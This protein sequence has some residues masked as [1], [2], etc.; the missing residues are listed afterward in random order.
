M[1]QR[2]SDAA[3]Q[4]RHCS[5]TLCTAA[6][7]A[8]F[9]SRASSCEQDRTWVTEQKRAEIAHGKLLAT[10]AHRFFVGRRFCLR[11]GAPVLQR[12]QELVTEGEQRDPCLL[13]ARVKAAPPR[14][15]L[16][17]A[18]ERQP[19]ASGSPYNTAHHEIMRT[20]VP[21]NTSPFVYEPT[22]GFDA[23][24]TV[25]ALFDALDAAERGEVEERGAAVE[26]WRAQLKE[27]KRD[28]AVA[29]RAKRLRQRLNGLDQWMRVSNDDRSSTPLSTRMPWNS[30]REMCD[31]LP[32][33]HDAFADSPLQ[34]LSSFGAK[35]VITSVWRAIRPLPAEARLEVSP[36]FAGALVSYSPVALRQL[37]PSPTWL[38]ARLHLLAAQRMPD[39]M[40]ELEL[41]ALAV[42]RYAPTNSGAVA[43]GHAGRPVRLDVLLSY[44]VP[45]AGRWSYSRQA[46]IKRLYEASGAAPTQWDLAEYVPISPRGG[47][48]CTMKLTLR[49]S[50]GALYD[51]AP[52]LRELREGVAAAELDDLDAACAQL[53][54]TVRRFQD[55]F[56]AGGGTRAGLW[57]AALDSVGE[58]L[59]VFSQGRQSLWLDLRTEVAEAQERLGAALGALWRH[60]G[61]RLARGASGGATQLL[62][63]DAVGL[64]GFLAGARWRA[65]LTPA[66][67][68][69]LPLSPF[70]HRAPF[71]HS[72]APGCVRGWPANPRRHKHVAHPRG[73]LEDSNR[74][75]LVGI[76]VMRHYVLFERSPVFGAVLS[77]APAAHSAAPA[78]RARPE[79]DAQME[80]LADGDESAASTDASHS[81][82]E[83]D[84]D[85][86]P[87]ALGV[88]PL[89]PLDE[90]EAMLSS[91]D[92]D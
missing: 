54:A 51:L 85:A 72:Q 47:R 31:A 64:T 89:A 20:R 75:A 35:N 1:T 79:A 67:V 18:I 13:A 26:S 82:S 39:T 56:A 5:L 80:E 14:L 55:A 17:Y 48:T 11:E 71:V 29:N 38:G 74:G 8:P 22:A 49:T 30:V 70:V 65:G 90:S 19:T 15:Q 25:A 16:V 52:A 91:D 46:G 32:G 12:F 9:D 88:A 50:L 61:R 43:A 68:A 4:R 37:D 59:P 69:C 81:S 36:D 10:R 28:K 42:G 76:L 66:D 92:G 21:E 45:P 44:D 33:L 63:Y 60:V 73:D 77:S 34:D 27:M 23:R 3:T 62:L 24:E 41:A 40:P 53:C 87:Y 58:D 2:W 84:D 86:G 83:S 78:A 6:Q 57:M 7:N